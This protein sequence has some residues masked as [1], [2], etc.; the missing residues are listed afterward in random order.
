MNN[1]ISRTL[2]SFNQSSS[3]LISQSGVAWSLIQ[4]ISIGASFN[5]FVV[6]RST[7]SNAR[8]NVLIFN[9]SSFQIFKRKF[10]FVIVLSLEANLK[11]IILLILNK[12]QSEANDGE[13]RLQFTPFG[14][15][16]YL[17]LNSNIHYILQ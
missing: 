17:S 2:V 10:H 1:I 12:Y 5:G 16:G 8:Y 7:V 6:F 11:E 9:Y 15:S 4:P 13:T 14:H 3:A